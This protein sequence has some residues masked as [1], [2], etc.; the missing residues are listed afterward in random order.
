M[1]GP[2]LITLILVLSSQAH[3]LD[4]DFYIGASG[5]D[6]SY[7]KNSFTTNFFYATPKDDPAYSLFAG[8]TI[9]EA[10]IFEVAYSNFDTESSDIRSCS[11]SSACKTINYD[12]EIDT[13]ALYTG[14]KSKGPLYYLFKVGYI[15]GESRLEGP[16]S[17]YS[18][19]TLSGISVALGTGVKLGKFRFEIQETTVK[20]S[21]RFTNIGLSYH[22]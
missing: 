19:N 6:A 13:Y 14:V 11:F 8:I 2:T 4:T 1:K 20:S 12:V 15:Y 18:E 17:T 5:G 3:A 16:F 21:L 9:E 22:F 7:S 10:I